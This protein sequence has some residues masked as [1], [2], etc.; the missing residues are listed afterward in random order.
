M[1]ILVSQSTGSGAY[2]L[3]STD[4]IDTFYGL[5]TKAETLSYSGTGTLKVVDVSNGDSVHLS[6]AS[7]GFK[8]KV[9]GNKVT[10]TDAAS[11]HTVDLGAFATGENVTVQFS[12]GVSLTIAAAKPGAST[13]YTATP[14]VGWG[15]ALTL[16]STVQGLF[17]ETDHAAPTLV[18]AAIDGSTLVLT[19]SETLDATHVPVKGD[20]AVLV[21]AVANAVTGVS[22]DAALKTV[23]LALSTP[24]LRTDSVTVSYT[25]PAVNNTTANNAIQDT[26]GNDASALAATLVT[27]NTLAQSAVAKSLD[28][29][30]G[31]DSAATSYDAGLGA[32]IFSD[33]IAT[34]SYARITNFGAND[35]IIFTGLTTDVSYETFDNNIVIT[36]KDGVGHTSEIVLVGVGD[37]AVGSFGSFNNRADLG[38]VTFF[39]PG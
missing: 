4:T 1:A 6:V 14:S 35:S 2:T 29:N 34:T 37:P 7:T 38:D 32:F 12:D 24:V 15:S 16:S 10:L 9:L 33:V 26:A 25:A 27:N 19:Y 3:G 5:S 22:V 30:P 31:V 20:F 23:T 21:G 18:S 8:A 13:V 11:G 36:G 28:T 39:T 17:V